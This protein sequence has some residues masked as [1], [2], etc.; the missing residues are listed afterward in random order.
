VKSSVSRTSVNRRNTENSGDTSAS[1][2][3]GTQEA[4][5]PS[6]A[7]NEVNRSDLVSDGEA[8]R[9]V[10]RLSVLTPRLPLRRSREALNVRVCEVEIP[11]LD[12][13][14]RVMVGLLT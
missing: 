8:V 11:T 1:S 5:S 2:P 9:L 6:V 12:V 10:L 14:K 3:K 4:L 13:A 7:D